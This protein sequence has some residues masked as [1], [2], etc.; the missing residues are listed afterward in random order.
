MM[1]PIGTLIAEGW[2]PSDLDNLTKRLRLRPGNITALL[3][4]DHLNYVHAINRASGYRFRVGYHENE[5]LSPMIAA[6]VSTYKFK[7]MVIDWAE[8][9]IIIDISGHYELYRCRALSQRAK[10]DKIIK[11]Q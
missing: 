2:L 3:G 5:R 4:D 11:V 8:N 9:L 6:V 1:K 10:I 7:D